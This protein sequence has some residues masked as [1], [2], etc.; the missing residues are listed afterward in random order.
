MKTLSFLYSALFVLFL[1]QLGCSSQS[2]EAEKFVQA[3][4]K[5]NASEKKE[6]YIDGLITDPGFLEKQVKPKRESRTF[7]FLENVGQVI[8][9]K[10]KPVREIKYYTHH[11]NYSAYFMNDRVSLVFRQNSP[12][13][14]ETPA[15]QPE[16][17]S[18]HVPANNLSSHDT[19]NVQRID[20]LFLDINKQVSIVPIDI[21]SATYK[22]YTGSINS[23]KNILPCEKIRYVEIYKGIDLLFY[24]DSK[25]A[26]KFDFIVKPGA[27]PSQIRL[28]YI[29]ADQVN[30]TGD[31]TIHVKA[32][33]SEFTEPEPVSYQDKKSIATRYHVHKDNSFGFKVDSFHPDL[34][35]I[36]DPHILHVNV[37]EGNMQDKITEGILSTSGHYFVTGNTES[38]V[39][40][41]IGFTNNFPGSQNA[42]IMAFD[43][44]G[45]LFW[46]TYLGIT[47]PAASN[48]IVGSNAISYLPRQ[49][50]LI[51]G[52]YTN[53]TLPEAKNHF[54]A[55][56]SLPGQIFYDGYTAAFDFSGS[57]LWTFHY[58]GP[59]NDVI[60][61]IIVDNLDNIYVTGYSFS[62]TLPY[63]NESRAR[64]NDNRYRNNMNGFAAK[65][66]ASAHHFNAYS[67]YSSWSS[68]T[69]RTIRGKTVAI[70]F[71][72]YGNIV[73]AGG[74]AGRDSYDSQFPWAGSYWPL[75]Q[76]YVGIFNSENG[77]Q[78]FQSTGDLIQKKVSFYNDIQI[79][80]NNNY[81]LS[82][83]AIDRPYTNERI[84]TAAEY[85]IL[86]TI[87]E[88]DLSSWTS[89]I[90]GGSL[91]DMATSGYMLGNDLYV[92]GY[93]DSGSGRFVLN[94]PFPYTSGTHN[95]DADVM[96]MKLD[97]QTAAI[98]TS[99]PLGNSRGDF[100]N[101][102]LSYPFPTEPQLM[103]FG[104]MAFQERNETY[105]GVPFTN[106]TFIGANGLAVR[107]DPET[108][109]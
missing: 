78:L 86:V 99:Y 73:V 92:T 69:A 63:L 25:G 57:L 42:F 28:K 64:E 30:F 55:D 16:A 106:Q 48:K 32:R 43:Y 2:S 12:E 58:G 80:L 79:D 37:L 49:Q 9:P 103:V 75:Y 8:D 109:P 93:A 107:L 22:F 33:F 4:Q 17:G 44:I 15:K 82:G 70:T 102:I 77:N 71:D 52:G 98:N 104:S 19:I 18:T 13:G 29:G 23:G 72:P 20:L 84:Y 81:L 50:A 27:D 11:G 56:V 60:E 87:I 7:D 96:M 1:F 41:N 46:A 3:L 34:E 14:K 39:F 61:D 38:D 35:F 10:S 89:Q 36:I 67:L 91:A 74:N 21:G 76:A 53:N 65:L 5:L 26:L 95:G 108:M 47:D 31:G 24:G 62:F 45:N 94:S 68:F 105:L 83:Y 100:A 88:P 97:L 101:H 54:I 6:P 66:G 59:S 40:P 51:I 85:D 90:I